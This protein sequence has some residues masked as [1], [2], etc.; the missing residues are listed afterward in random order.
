MSTVAKEFLK[1][2]RED[3]NLHSWIHVTLSEHILAQVVGLRTSRGAWMAIE[4]RFV[5][6]SHTHTIELKQQIQ[7][8]QKGNLSR[9]Y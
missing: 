2:N 1:W 5:S 8:I 4:Q 9:P 6:I 7:N 3:Q